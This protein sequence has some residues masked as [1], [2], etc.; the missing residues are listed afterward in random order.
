MILFYRYQHKWAHGD[1]NWEWGHQVV[2]PR[3]DLETLKE[4]IGN[5]LCDQYGW[6]D[7]YRG[8]DVEWVEDPPV[9]ELQKVAQRYASSAGYY[10]KTAYALLARL[11]E[12]TGVNEHLEALRRAQSALAELESVVFLA[13]LID[14]LVVEQPVVNDYLSGLQFKQVQHLLERLKHAQDRQKACARS[15]RDAYN[16]AETWDEGPHPHTRTAACGEPQVAL[17]YALWVDKAPCSE[18]RAAAYKDPAVA[19]LYDRD[20]GPEE[21]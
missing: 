4:D 16:F 11:G 17:S 6:S 14:T 21:S 10:Q 19:V 13:E 5:E 3:E 12:K 15:P 9:E 8:V 20:L 1:D 7:K 18:T 2:S